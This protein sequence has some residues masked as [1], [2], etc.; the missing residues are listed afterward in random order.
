MKIRFFFHGKSGGKKPQRV[1]KGKGAVDVRALRGGVTWKKVRSTPRDSAG[2]GPFFPPR[3]AARRGQDCP[4][5]QLPRRGA[6]KKG[7]CCWAS[8]FLWHVCSLGGAE[9]RDEMKSEIPSSRNCNNMQRGREK[10][11]LPKGVEGSGTFLDNA[12]SQPIGTM[13]FSHF[14]LSFF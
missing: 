12:K 2:I 1:I 5:A 13:F 7:L 3:V 14:Q 11:A 4:A 10:R 8:S 9:G 6:R